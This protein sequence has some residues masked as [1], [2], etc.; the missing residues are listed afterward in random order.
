MNSLAQRIATRLKSLRQLRG[1]SLDVTS[2]HTGVSKA[3][4]GQIERGESSP[5]IAT[6]WKIATGFNCSFSLFLDDEPQQ[7]QP[8]TYKS[9]LPMAMPATNNNMLVTPL[10]PYDQELGFELFVI[11]LL[12]GYE[13]NSLPHASK[14]VEHVIP[15]QGTLEVYVIDRWYTL[16][17]HKGLRFQAD[18]PHGYRNCS[19]E[20][21]IFH[22]IIHYPKVLTI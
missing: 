12:P 3:M 19:R 13:H 1:W 11:E 2:H 7:E 16:A 17:P 18:Q 20:K 22:N 10:F 5:T 8:L 14:V 4:L 9:C 15:I 21:V 6:L